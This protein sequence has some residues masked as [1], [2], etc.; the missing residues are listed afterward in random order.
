MAAD[1]RERAKQKAQARAKRFA[2][3]NPGVAELRKLIGE[4]GG[5]PA[6]IRRELRPMLKVAGQKALT[7]ARANA[8]WSKRIPRATRLSVSFSK[9]RAGIALQTNK[10]RAPHARPHEHQGRG[11]YFRHP[12]MGNRRNWVRQKARPFLWPAAAPLMRGIDEQIGQAADEAARKLGF[13]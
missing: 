11:G 5:L 1:Y 6:D 8:S 7:D 2:R 13:K 10:N 3:R 12:V 4:V 9:R